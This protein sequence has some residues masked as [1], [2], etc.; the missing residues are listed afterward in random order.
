MP[1]FQHKVISISALEKGIPEAILQ[2]LGVEGW[3]LVAVEG[4]SAFLKKS[5]DLPAAAQMPVLVHQPSPPASPAQLGD[6]SS[7][8]PRHWL[9]STID[10][11]TKKEML[12]DQQSGLKSAPHQHMA[13]AI[14]N[15]DRTVVRGKTENVLGHEHNIKILGT[16]EESD[17]HCH[18]TESYPQ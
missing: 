2:G 18:T 4:G 9:P 13:Y 12:T 5:E 6:S 15:S 14:I 8:N 7:D 1:K 10:G 3:E 16:T 11:Q 17:G